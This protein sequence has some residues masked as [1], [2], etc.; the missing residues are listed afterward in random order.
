MSENIIL[1]N[2][3][4]TNRL[5][6]DRFVHEGQIYFIADMK[7]ASLS[8]GFLEPTVMRITFKSGEKKTL[9]LE[10]FPIRRF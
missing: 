8:C 5:F 7:Q 6:R 2:K 4:G 3:R 9:E 10:L 1:E